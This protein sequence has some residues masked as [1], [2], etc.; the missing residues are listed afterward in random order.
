M[1]DS[2]SQNLDHIAIDDDDDAS[3]LLREKSH[4][5]GLA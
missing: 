4:R 1:T 3:M 2:K 5:A